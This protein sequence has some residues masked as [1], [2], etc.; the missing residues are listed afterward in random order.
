[1]S[2]RRK[3]TENERSHKIERFCISLS[4]LAGDVSFM[5]KRQ[6]AAAVPLRFFLARESFLKIR[7]ADS[8]TR[9][10]LLAIIDLLVRGA[11]RAKGR[12]RCSDGNR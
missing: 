11:V 10:L 6:A 8:N 3:D 2:N 9:A 4:C 5:E 7:Q 12:Q 1:M